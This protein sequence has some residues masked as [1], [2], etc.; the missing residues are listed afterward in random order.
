MQ[1]KNEQEQVTNIQKLNLSHNELQ[2]SDLLILL[3]KKQLKNL[4]HLD[5]SYNQI[6]QDFEQCINEKQF[7]QNLNKIEFLSLKGNLLHKNFVQQLL[8]KKYIQLPNLQE[9]DIQQTQQ[10]YGIIPHIQDLQLNQADL[11]KIIKEF[12][13]KSFINTP[14]LINLYADDAYFWSYR[15][16]F[17][18]LVEEGFLLNLQ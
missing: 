14:Q 12:L 7:I 11:I 15:E 5:I 13:Q 9:L 2:L 4:I 6:K 10:I 8:F 18:A 1:D 17:I 3:G 16:Q